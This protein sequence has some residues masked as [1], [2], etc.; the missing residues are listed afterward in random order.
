MIHC[1]KHQATFQALDTMDEISLRN[2]ENKGGSSV[3]TSGEARVLENAPRWERAFVVC[4]GRNTEHK[5][6]LR[7]IIIRRLWDNLV[8]FLMSN[9]VPLINLGRHSFI[10]AMHKPL[11]DAA[12][13][14]KSKRQT[15]RDLP[16]KE[17]IDFLCF[18]KGH[19]EL[20]ME[21]FR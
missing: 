1:I 20:T 5:H 10:P 16:I 15:N 19:V 4:G 11:R 18:S 17:S 12:R 9:L 21:T 7:T 13:V 8:P 2:C 14:K 6:G 3:E